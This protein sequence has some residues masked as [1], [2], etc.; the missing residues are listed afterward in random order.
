MPEPRAP[1]RGQAFC[2]AL[3]K[4]AA[5][6]LRH[7]CGMPALS[8]LPAPC[9]APTIGK[10]TVSN[11]SNG[12]M[13]ADG[14]VQLIDGRAPLDPATNLIFNDKQLNW[15]ESIAECNKMCAHLATFSSQADQHEAEEYFK[16][17]VRRHGWLVPWGGARSRCWR[18][19]PMAAAPP[20]QRCRWQG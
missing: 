16:S 14:T 4:Q 17:Q 10:Y 18:P 6:P 1:H 9:A 3:S 11:P 13:N 20:L 12:T 15:E 5:A 8:S 2:C 7:P 19:P